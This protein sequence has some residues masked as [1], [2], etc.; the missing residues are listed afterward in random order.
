MEEN[1]NEIV[2]IGDGIYQIKYYWLGMSD[3]YC[4]LILG[5]EKALMIDTCYSTTHALEYARTVTDLPIEVVNTHGHF[6]HIGGNGDFEN[7]YLSE[8]DYITAKE[9]SD[10]EFLSNMMKCFEEKNE[11]MKTFLSYGENRGTMEETLKSK[12]VVYMPLPKEGHFELGGRKVTFISTPGHTRGSICL[13]DEKTGYFFV[14]D[15]AC[16]E[17]VLLGFDHSTSVTEYLVSIRKMKDYYLLNGGT[18]IIPS[19][20]ALPVREDIFTRYETMCEEIISG[21]L[22][23][24]EHDDGISQGKSAKLNQLQIVYRK[25]K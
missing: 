7:V 22:K 2:K 25:I 16:E 13:L 21:E 12:P 18:K 15:M 5:Q 4:F 14:G 11:L 1:K 17:A 9:H 19:H 8:E 23:G 20:H 10:Y 3:V 24:Q 6:D